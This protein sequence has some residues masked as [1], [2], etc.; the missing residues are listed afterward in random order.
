MREVGEEEELARVHHLRNAW[1]LS[2]YNETFYHLTVYN[3]NT[4]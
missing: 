3:K 1:P 2:K 4:E